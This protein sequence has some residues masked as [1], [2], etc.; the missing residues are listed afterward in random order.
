MVQK[1]WNMIETLAHEHSSKNAQW[2][3]SKAYQH[4][5]VK[6]K[7]VFKSLWVIVLWR[8]VALVLEGLIKKS[9]LDISMFSL[10][11]PSH[12]FLHLPFRSLYSL[13]SIFRTWACSSRAPARPGP[14]WPS[15]CSCGSHATAP[16]SQTSPGSSRRKA[17]SLAVRW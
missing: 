8:K 2:E 14:A 7:M 13:R 16:P 6:I 5:R 4:D 10:S 1:S 12:K 11:M 17:C 15:S 3:L 9:I